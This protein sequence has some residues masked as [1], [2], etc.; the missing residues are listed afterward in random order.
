MMVIAFGCDH[1]GHD[2]KLALISHVTKLG[3]ETV[4][5]GTNSLTMAHSATYAKKLCR[6]IVAGKA[7]RG[8]L[9]C[10]TG[11]G[12]SI[13]ANKFNGIR[14]VLANDIYTAR[15]SMRHNNTNVICLGS[16]NLNE[17]RANE[18]LKAWLET[19]FENSQR[20]TFRLKMIREIEEEQKTLC[21]S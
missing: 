17:E 18:L 5:V 11:V 21:V 10:S 20:R 4:D 2:L 14:A 13:C 1:R 15:L 19:S 3:Y 8:V 16:D 9:I 6:T 7:E 12:M